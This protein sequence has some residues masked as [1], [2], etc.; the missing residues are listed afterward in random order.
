MLKRL[1]NDTGIKIVV[2]VFNGEIH[3]ELVTEMDDAICSITK[4]DL[5]EYITSL[6]NEV[7]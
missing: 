4:Q 6:E 3:Y 2:Y 1:F 7:K 5:F